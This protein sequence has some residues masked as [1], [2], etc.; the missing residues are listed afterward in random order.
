MESGWA[1]GHNI[2]EDFPFF[3]SQNMLFFCPCFSKSIY[4]D[5]FAIPVKHS[6]PESKASPSQTIMN[7]RIGQ[8]LRTKRAQVHAR[9]YIQQNLS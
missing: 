8:R 5:A 4:R 7:C 6:D 2:H 9:T 1:Y 3:D